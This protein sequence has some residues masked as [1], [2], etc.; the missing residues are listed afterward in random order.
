MP[1]AGEHPKHGKRLDGRIALVTGASRGIG[2]AVAKRFAR[3]GAHLILVA[4]T[5]AGLE[6]VDDEVRKISGTPATLAPLD[7][8]DFD[9]IDKLGAALFERFHKLDVLVGNAGLLGTLSPI[10]HIDPKTWDQVMAVNVTANWRL[11][12]SLDPLLRASAAGRA[13]FVTSTVGREARPYWG[14]YAVSKC[15]LEMMA[16]IYAAEV[17]K[18]NVRINLI[19]PGPTRTGMRAEAFPGEDPATVK[20]PEALTDAFVEL[21]E[22]ACARN[23]ELVRAF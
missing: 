1:G 16:M 17:A 14:A 15:A 8:T 10:G 19:N 23:G 9:A 11:I 3:E 21:A 18:T 2:A 22:A 5:Q 7:L 20:P 13:V 4:R 12:R 6:E